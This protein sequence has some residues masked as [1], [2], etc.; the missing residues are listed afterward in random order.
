MSAA[1]GIIAELMGKI[2]FL[3]FRD[4]GND[5]RKHGANRVFRESRMFT[6]KAIVSYGKSARVSIT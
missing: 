5:W 6:A 2:M 1:R 4:R 3:V